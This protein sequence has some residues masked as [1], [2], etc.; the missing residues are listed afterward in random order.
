[1]Q[2]GWNL[3]PGR[4]LGRVQCSAPHYYQRGWFIPLRRGDRL[5]SCG[6]YIVRPRSQRAVRRDPRRA[7]PDREGI[8]RHADPGLFRR[9]D[10]RCR[11]CGEAGRRRKRGSNLQEIIHD[12]ARSLREA[13]RSVAGLCRRGPAA[14]GGWRVDRPSG[15]GRS[16][17]PERGAPVEVR[18]NR[19]RCPPKWSTP[20]PHRSGGRHQ[21]GQARRAY[22]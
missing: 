13:R 15:P 4:K 22:I 21:F 20:A 3:R 19:R 6:W 9:H 7:Q 5:R 12:A 11:R 8:A 18:T 2:C 10:G 17:K 14:F 16:P 1:M